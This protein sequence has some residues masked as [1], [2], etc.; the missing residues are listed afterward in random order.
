MIMD[1]GLQQNWVSAFDNW[2]RAQKRFD[3]AGQIGNAAL[4][5]YLRDHVDT[6]ARAYNAATKAINNA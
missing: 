2:E 4:I 5:N 3:A 6:A 1:V